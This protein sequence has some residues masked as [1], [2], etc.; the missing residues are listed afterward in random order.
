MLKNI[1]TT[2]KNFIKDN[3]NQ[4]WLF[5]ALLLVA[6]LLFAAIVVKIYSNAFGTLTFPTTATP[7]TLISIRA[8]WGQIGDFF[9]GVLNP[10]FGFVSLFAL[11]VTIAYQARSLRVSSEELKLSR[12]ELNKS[13]TA[14]ASQNKAIELQSFEQTFFSWLAT[15]QSLL[16]S[17]ED[18]T[19]YGFLSGNRETVIKKGRAQLYKWW[20]KSLKETTLWSHFNSFNEL[21]NVV[22]DESINK[23]YISAPSEAKNREKYYI[24]FTAK[25]H[26]DAITGFIL[27]EWNELYKSEE[28]Q[29]DNLFRTL[30][31]LLS[32]IDS[33]QEARLNNAQKWLYISIVRSQ[34]SWIEMVYLYFNGLTE[35]GKK[36][37]SISEKYALFNNLTFDS[38]AS[39]DVLKIYLSNDD[40]YRLSAYDSEVARAKLRL[41]IT[42]EQTLANAATGSI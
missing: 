34:L 38:D 33:Q 24:T 22:P 20:E 25:L 3:D 21:A 41:P 7:S 4:M 36:F 42:S 23:A 26:P 5:I 8:E 30:Y 17:I 28:Y 9:G 10:L 19:V 35:R 12:E 15:Y 39:I 31:S 1:C 6:V 27:S 16:N 29:L 11:L 2:I 13:S 32:W 37:K 14:L 40:S 18:E